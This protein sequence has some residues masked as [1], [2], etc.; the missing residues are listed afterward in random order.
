[1][2][3]DSFSDAVI[4][5]GGFGERLWPASSPSFPKQFMKISDGI[6]FLQAAI[7]R[8]L[9]LNL[10]GKIL[11]ITRPEIKDEL[12]RQVLDLKLKVKSEKDKAKIENDVIVIAEPCPRH[13]C[14]PLLLACKFLRMIDGKEHSILVLTSDQVISPITAFVS[15][16]KKA[17]FWACKGKFVCFAIPPTEPSTGFGYIKTGDLL[18]TEDMEAF[19]IDSFKEKPDIETAKTYLTSGQYAWNSGMFGF[20]SSLFTEE[21]KQYEP[22]IFESFASFDNSSLPEIKS[23]NGVKYIDSWEP[24]KKAYDTIKGI[25]VDNA[26]AERTKR[27]VAVKASFDWDDVGS[28]D[29][30]EK[31]FSEG[32]DGFVSVNSNGNFV[33]SDIPVA[34]SGVSDLIIVVKNG[35][36]LVMKKG[37]SNSMRE[38]VKKIKEKE[39]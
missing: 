1:M 9:A 4:L 3:N 27:A 31:H 16:C 37:E 11:I 5:A 34:L 21:I 32:E 8:A 30:F 25:A 24:M 35:R 12:T 39:T 17:A 36:L 7:L 23:L 10:S 22:E 15:D 19:E 28:W 20:T 18:D 13:T 14:P 33:Y 38:I 29:A 6:S 2:K 26:I